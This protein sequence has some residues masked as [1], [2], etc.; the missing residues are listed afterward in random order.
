M[1]LKKIVG[2]LREL[3]EKHPKLYEIFKFLVVG[4]LAT[5]IDFVFMS[6]VLYAWDPS[7]YGHNFWRVFVGGGRPSIGAT[8]VGTAVGFLIGLTFNYFLSIIF[9]FA[10]AGNSSKKAKTTWGVFLFVAFST[11]G[12]GIHV[13]GM[14]I[15][16]GI[17]HLNEWIVKIVLTIIVLVFNYITRKIFIFKDHSNKNTGA[18]ADPIKENKEALLARKEVVG[19][20]PSGN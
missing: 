17:I 20:E 5:L 10:G 18:P 1:S 13:L 7:I 6:I 9:V 8:V 2:K 15:F 16:N 11:A 14:Y 3:T 12:L 4:T 19:G